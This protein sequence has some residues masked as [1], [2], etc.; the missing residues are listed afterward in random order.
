MHTLHLNYITHFAD[1]DEEE[2][3]DDS[4]RVPCFPYL[5]TLVMS[6]QAPSSSADPIVTCVPPVSA[7]WP[8]RG[9]QPPSWI[10]ELLRNCPSLERLE[11]VVIDL[12]HH[13]S[14]ECIDTVRTA[15][16]G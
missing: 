9:G 8:S 13:D 11:G 10:R 3:N 5:R 2:D 15:G 4:L 1:S 16:P 12:E 7:A 6:A 14:P